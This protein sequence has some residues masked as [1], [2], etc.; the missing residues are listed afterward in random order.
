MP[1]S[2]TLVAPPHTVAPLEAFAVPAQI[3]GST[4][5]NRA[6]GGVRQ[7]RTDND[8]DAI[9]AWLARFLD[10]QT[11]FDSYRAPPRA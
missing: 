10:K 4:G 1:D 2:N 11:T 9:K 6:Q 8:I 5:S 7:I 3:D